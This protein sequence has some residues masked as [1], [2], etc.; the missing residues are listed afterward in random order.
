MPV[1]GHAQLASLA[2]NVV[3]RGQTIDCGRL[4]SWKGAK[5]CCCKHRSERERTTFHGSIVPRNANLNSV[6][7]DRGKYP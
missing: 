6:N 1:I 7:G 5:C 2:T 4:N 3:H